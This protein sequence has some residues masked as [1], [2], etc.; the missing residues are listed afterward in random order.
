[1]S[2]TL[3]SLFSLV[4]LLLISGCSTIRVTPN[5]CQTDGVWGDNPTLS[6]ELTLQDLKDEEKIDERAKRSYFTFSRTTARIKDIAEE[7][8]INCREIKKM[9]VEITSK[10]FF[11]KE[12]KLKIVKK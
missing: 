10:L 3:F 5:G 4:V 2:K 11:F 7:A 1:M 6:R 9:R 12:V 8:S